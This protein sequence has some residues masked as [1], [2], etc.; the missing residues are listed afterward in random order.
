MY[1]G[2]T[3]IIDYT[4]CHR[5]N[6]METNTIMSVDDMNTITLMK[7]VKIRHPGCV[8]VA[9]TD[10]MRRKPLVLTQRVLFTSQLNQIE[11]Q[12][13]VDL[14][15]TATQTQFDD[16]ESVCSSH[17]DSH[18][19]CYN[20]HDDASI[21]SSS[22]ADECTSSPD[23]ECCES[24][25]CTESIVTSC[26]DDGHITLHKVNYDHDHIGLFSNNFIKLS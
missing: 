9:C 19:T 7:G 15:H 6:Y 3:V 12:T 17:N 18:T 14:N 22:E 1:P 20:S 8:M 13:V 26:E 24:L 11:T 25:H 10:T 4:F 5:H 2:D 23:S 16:E 21:C